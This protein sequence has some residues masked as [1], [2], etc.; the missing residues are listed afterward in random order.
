[1]Y[2][3]P[4]LQAARFDVVTL[5]LS[6]GRAETRAALLRHQAAA[7]EAGAEARARPVRRCAACVCCADMPPARRTR[8][9]S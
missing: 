5:D 9:C 6:A 1:M 3:L 2:A 4:A 8:A 7:Q